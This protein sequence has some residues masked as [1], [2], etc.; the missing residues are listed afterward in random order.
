MIVDP[1]HSELQAEARKLSVSFQSRPAIA[2]Q[3]ATVTDEGS[4]ARFGTILEDEMSKRNNRRRTRI[5]EVCS[6]ASSI[7][8]T[9]SGIAE[10]AKAADQTAGGLTYGSVSFLLTV[11][12]LPHFILMV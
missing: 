4:L 7:L 5:L 10:I 11:S 8:R 9:Y 1:I 3:V 6:T 2:K 12:I